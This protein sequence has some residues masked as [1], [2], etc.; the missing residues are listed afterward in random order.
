MESLEYTQ[1]VL[2]EL[3]SYRKIQKELVEDTEELV[4]KGRGT[5]GAV[6]R[7]GNVRGSCWIRERLESV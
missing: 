5:F 3:N 4:Y 6:G 1:H 2:E 7:E